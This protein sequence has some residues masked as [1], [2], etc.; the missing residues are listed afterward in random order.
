MFAVLCCYAK[1]R[2][3]DTSNMLPD[4]Y[5]EEMKKDPNIKFDLDQNIWRT[6]FNIFLVMAFALKFTYLMRINPKFGLLNQMIEQ[7]F[8]DIKEYT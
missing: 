5:Y 7:V 6:L 3:N 1:M 2:W 4:I 8:S